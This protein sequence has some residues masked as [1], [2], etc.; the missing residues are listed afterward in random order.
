MKSSSILTAL[1]TVALASVTHGIQ[2]RLPFTGTS[3]PI[4]SLSKQ[5]Q[6]LLHVRGG[7][8]D[9]VTENDDI[10]TEEGMETVIET[11][12]ARMVS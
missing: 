8:Q 10:I 2:S 5:S 1:T 6:L 3:S 4:G 7:E 11:D 9:I 12:T